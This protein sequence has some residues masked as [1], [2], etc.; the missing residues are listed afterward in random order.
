MAS[1]KAALFFP[2][3]VA[4][5]VGIF[6]LDLLTP[7]GIIVWTFYVAPILLA[8]WSGRPRSVLLATLAAT[9]LTFVGFFLS[10]PGIALALALLNRCLGAGML[11]FITAVLVRQHFNT[12]LQRERDLS[13]S[14]LNSLPGIYFLYDEQGRFLRWNSR[15]EEVSGY[16]TAE[17]AQ[18]GPLDF[19]AGAEKE[20]LAERIAAVFRTGQA[21][22]EAEFVARN[23]RRTP[24]HFIGVRAEIDDRPCLLGMGIDVGARKRAEA[25][26]DRLMRELE[27]SLTVQKEHERELARLNRLYGALSQVNQA[28]VRTP[29]RDELFEKVC[30]I[31]V[32]QGGFHMPWIGWHDP[33]TRQIAPLAV[34]G[35]DKGYIRSINI[36]SD[37]RPEGRGPTGVAFRAGRS[38]ICNDML[39]NPITLPWRSELLRRGFNAS[40]VFPIRLKKEVCGTLTVYSE[41]PFFFQDKEV[42]LLEKAAGDLSF[43]LDKFAL[44]A[45]HQQAE[46]TLRSE[47]LFS[48]TM[49]ES[50]PGIL[51]FYDSAGRFL[52]W[53]RNFE[54]V[55]GYSG[56]E[57][58]RM[59]PL[60]FFTGEEKTRV[61]QG[62]AEVF[63]KGVS[64]VEAAFVAKDGAA[65]PYFFTGRRVLFEGKSCL[66][67][68]GIDIS[69]RKRAEDRLAE[70]ER[71][72][73]ELVEHANSIILRWNSEGRITFLN[74]YG[75]RFFGFSAEEIIGRHI[76]DTIVP[77]TESGGRDLA[78]LMEE[79]CADPEAFEQNVNENIRRNG[80]RV[81]IAWT[82][83]I[84]SDSRGKVVEF[85]SVGAD[86]TERKRAET[87]L[88]EAELRF[89][90]LFE[91]TPV[92]IV[93][94]NS[95]NASIIECNEQAARQL[96]YTSQEFC[97]LS[98][99]DIEVVQTSENAQRRLERTLR[100]GR[101]QFETH[102]RTRSGEI[103]EVF[104]SARLLELTGRTVIHCVFLDVTE[105][106][107]A[108][109]KVRESEARYRTLFEYAP[110]GI[111][112]ANS[113]S[114]Y[115]DA[116]PSICRML[117]YTR[118]EFIGLHAS[119]IVAETEI[120]HIPPALHVINGQS[121]HHREWWFRRKNG[122][123]FP[124][125]V[126]ATMMPDGNILGMI[127]DVTER[128][129]AESE[130]AKR[131]HAEAADRIKS[132]FLAT[133]SHELR[134]PLNSI[135]GFTGIILQGLA[136][137]LNPE[138]SKQLGMVRT[139]ARH[140]LAL[141]NDVLDISKIEAGQLEV[142]REPF[143]LQ[144]SIARVVAAVAPLA[145]KKGLLL[146][147]SLAA[148]LGQ[149]VSDERRFEQIL[150]NLLSNAVK[151]TD[152]GEI[153][154]IAKLID[155]FKPPAANSCQV[156]VRLEVS[157]TGI[158]IKPD[159]L[160][161]LFQP[162]RQIDSGLSR[163]HDGTGLGLAICRRL[164]DLMGGTITAES[165][166]EK[167][168]TFRVTLPLGGSPRP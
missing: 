18:R 42:A 167:G 27:A 168:S 115:L 117:N 22:I 84:V 48:D 14:I 79:I 34:C 36:Y 153:K 119:D 49:I 103:R 56:E 101:D 7:L 106:N 134:T 5:L 94:L 164:A 165:A 44:E 71:K 3:T 58:G 64:S 122:A 39:N 152:R 166:W 54:T 137:P 83:R 139:S 20:L 12:A 97:Q 130:R 95:A 67:G 82:N 37:D 93:V 150:L 24:Y 46:Q 138:Q 1:N 128:K 76:M 17:M 21:E 41:E 65:T 154:L 163:N 120:P 151:F 38:F 73:R 124:A 51:Y 144:R 114:Y 16:S 129:E 109:A 133:M 88:R 105:R 19:F 118:E 145:E 23:G 102:H 4:L 123:V 132:A 30:Q 11:W 108:E 68:M 111:V 57:I 53:N 25:E 43:A 160:G 40:A 13:N 33:E 2:A 35:D 52:R 50:M 9:I 60:G 32:E 80:D 143:D 158:G 162:F 99:S 121:D 77:P 135:I 6:V 156:A 131:Q 15:L 157:D 74:E 127:R 148:R 126:I 86:I 104:V 159:D 59:H 149:A 140:L 61:E 146:Q 10:P 91:Q 26:R 78:R 100:Q 8:Y 98:I 28:I 116:N 81:W 155:D 147:V 66:V 47:K 31:L 87:A 62:I 63:E 85:L 69:D 72:Y 70:S 110:D 29:T 141:V 96:E 125:E 45:A 75:Q 92:G 142:A 55:S 89:H 161:H 113:E 136:G 112:I 90:T 107:R